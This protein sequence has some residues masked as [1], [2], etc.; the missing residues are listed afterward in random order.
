MVGLGGG[1]A[2]RHLVDRFAFQKTLVQS[3]SGAGKQDV[4]PQLD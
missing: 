1:G 3:I 2:S 4:P